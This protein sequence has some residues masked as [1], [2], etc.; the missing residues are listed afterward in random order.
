MAQDVYAAFT[1]GDSDKSIGVVDADGISM[2]A[3]QGL[4]QIVKEKDAEI[5]EL[6]ARLSILEKTVSELA[7]GR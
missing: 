4:H 7:A 6:K 3:I 5:A 1:L 2:A